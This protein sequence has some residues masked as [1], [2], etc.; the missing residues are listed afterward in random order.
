[1]ACEGIPRGFPGRRALAEDA[2]DMT[3]PDL[4]QPPA[5]RAEP[6]E[7]HPK[8]ERLAYSPEE[9]AEALGISRHLVYDLLRTGQLR[10]R[11]AGN[12]RLIGLRQIEA[13]LAEDE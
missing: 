7:D 11:K 4:D 5:L 13:F 8:V 6:G 1:V 3:A 10:S 2:P 9:A 12:R